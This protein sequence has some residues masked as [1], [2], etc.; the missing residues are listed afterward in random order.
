MLSVTGS[1]VDELERCEPVGAY[2]LLHWAPVG[3][4]GNALNAI[5][6][7]RQLQNWLRVNNFQGVIFLSC[8]TCGIKMMVIE[9]RLK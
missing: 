9:A 5:I 1:C 2:Q 8:H 6:C 4:V 3:K 7:Q